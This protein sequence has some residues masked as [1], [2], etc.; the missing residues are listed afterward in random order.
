MNI[1]ENDLFCP[2]K[3]FTIFDQQYF[4]V[5]NKFCWLNFSIMSYILKLD[6]IIIFQTRCF[7][8]VCDFI[9]I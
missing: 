2:F 4:I 8:N 7:Q 6:V 1:F 3:F 5:L 9:S